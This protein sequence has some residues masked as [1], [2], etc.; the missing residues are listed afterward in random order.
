[1]VR[2]RW[3]I[4]QNGLAAA[5]TIYNIFGLLISG[6]KLQL[7]GHKKSKMIRDDDEVKV[8]STLLVDR[9]LMM[10]IVG[11]A[12]LGRSTLLVDRCLMMRI[13]GC[14]DL[15]RSRLGDLQ[16]RQIQT[17]PGSSACQTGDHRPLGKVVRGQ[18]MNESPTSRATGG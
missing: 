13:V 1:M 10:R 7:K 3:F 17:R 18:K 5:G 2:N 8:Q 16:R 12:D 4:A 15:G 9:C 11:C 6:D 14:A